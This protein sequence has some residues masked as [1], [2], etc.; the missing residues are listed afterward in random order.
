MVEAAGVRLHLPRLLPHR[1][2]AERLEQSGQP[3]LGNAPHILAADVRDGFA[4][5]A[6][7]Q[8][9]K[10]V[11]VLGLFTCHRGEHPRAIRVVV[12]EL[13]GEPRVCA[14]SLLLVGDGQAEDFRVG[15]LLD[16]PLSA[17]PPARLPDHPSK[18]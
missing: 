10:T 8:V 6:P 15:K 17:H 1:L 5:L 3:L 9:G 11:P 4:E 13:L 12:A 7:E 18:C 2:G 16:V 14:G